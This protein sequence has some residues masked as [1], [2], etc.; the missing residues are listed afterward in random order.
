MYTHDVGY[1][2]QKIHTPLI[3][4]HS[5]QISKWQLSPIIFSSYGEKYQGDHCQCHCTV[6]ELG[7]SAGL[8]FIS[9]HHL[10]QC[11]LSTTEQVVDTLAKVIPSTNTSDIVN[12]RELTAGVEHQF[13]VTA[14]LE[15]DGEV[16]EK[17]TFIPAML[18]FGKS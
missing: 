6:G 16:Y 8:I 12:I 13:Q 2:S 5:M 4:L 17:M 18:L 7:C 3:C 11:L 9:L 15:I 1:S 14:S 10:L